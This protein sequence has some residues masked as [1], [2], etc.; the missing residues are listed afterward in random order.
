[1]KDDQPREEAKR[2]QVKEISQVLA[3]SMPNFLKTKEKDAKGNWIDIE[4]KSKQ[5]AAA[6][7]Q[8]S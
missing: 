4:P 7:A 1:M 3:S 8:S 6:A 5:K 2:N